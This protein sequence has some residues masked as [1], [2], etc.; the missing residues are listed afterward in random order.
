[1]RIIALTFLLM[2]AVTGFAQEIN[3]IPKPAEVKLPATPGK[4][5]ITPA[6][7]IVLEG[8]GMENSVNFLND[9]LS[10]FYGFRLKTAKTRP[11][12]NVIALN[13]ER[14]DNPLP[15]AYVF[16]SDKN[17][18]YIAGDNETGVFYGIQSLIQLLPVANSPKTNSLSLPWVSINDQ[19]RFEYRGLHL[20][21]CRH[22]F[23]VD[24]IKKYIDYM[25][26]HKLNYFHWHLTDDQGWRIEIKKYPNLVKAG[27]YR[28]GT[29]IGRYPGTGN[30]NTPYGG[31][32]TQAQIKEV[33]AYAKKRYITIIPEIE[34][35]GHGSA[36]IAAYPY[37]SCFS[38]EPTKITT[39][40]SELSK[41][42]QSQGRI[43]LVQE[44][45]GV[46]DDV[47][48]AGND[49][50]FTFLQNV[51]DEVIALFPSSYIHIGGDECPKNNWKRCPKCQ[52]RIKDLHLKDEHELQSYFIQRIEKYVNS[53]KRNIIGWDEILEGG[54]APNATV[55][56]WRG[57][58][59]GIA[60]ARQN[61]D[62]IMTP[63]TYCYLDH[64]QSRNEDSV[65]I[66][67]YLPLE[68]VYKYNPV[69]DSLTAEQ[70]KHILGAQGNVWT[71][72]MNNTRKVEY[73]IFPRLS[74]LS[75]VLWSPLDKKDYPDFE[76]RLATAFQRYDLW[77]T[78]YSKAYFDI[79]ASILPAPDNDGVLWKL[80]SKLKDV[81]FSYTNATASNASNP[82]FSPIRVTNSGTLG[83]RLSKNGKIMR[84]VSQ[85]FSFNKATGKNI[86]LTASP[87]DK[88]PGNVG[89]FGLV[90]GALS[91]KGI[92]SVEWLGWEG[93]DMEAIIDLG[94]EKS[95]SKVNCHLL[96]QTPSWIYLP[97]SVEVFTSADG[98]NFTS[99][100]KTSSYTP[101]TLTM[102][103]ATIAVSPVTTRYIKVFAKNY[104]K[105]GSGLP[106]AGNPA[107]LFV[108]EI[109]VE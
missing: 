43:K 100:G 105:I 92:S 109:Q 8:S 36:A 3:I 30:T 1:M 26:M 32:Y 47:F 79:A 33:I 103:N 72:Y 77:K 28:D 14:L 24:F 98:N 25:A 10:R 65:T 96:D 94:S 63:G 31:Y 55:M 4:F 52:Q 39:N 40:P 97:S 59:G 21:V 62:V 82:Y 71:E 89:A 95:I 7:T 87:A 15:G 99:A 11:N 12:K 46:F 45:W 53:K 44:T 34:M 66:G 20:D 90:N 17:G 80:E 27:A 73:M 50:T 85:N 75:E 76:K 74:A 58:A 60:A 22:F 88:W 61:H 56:S 104:G 18:V 23:P 19:P 38:A 67:G 78:N 9:Y 57:E 101:D 16:T 41:T 69:P 83:G 106:G 51:L 2:G 48:C 81:E 29:I 93:G 84:T 86:K 91:D 35:P 108:D 42:Q 68:Q 64:A 13:Y 107:W 6:T 37:L 5:T 70:A 54:L 49:S 102:Y